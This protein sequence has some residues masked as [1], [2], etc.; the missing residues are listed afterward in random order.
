MGKTF[1]IVG[2]SSSGKD[3]IYKRLLEDERLAFLED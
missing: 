3:T 2:K 1:C